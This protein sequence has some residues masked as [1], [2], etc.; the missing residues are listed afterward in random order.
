MDYTKTD[1]LCTKHRLWKKGSLVMSLV[2]QALANGY[3]FKEVVIGEPN[4]FIFAD[5]YE[6]LA[7]LF[8]KRGYYGI[9]I[10][11]IYQSAILEI[12]SNMDGVNNVQYT[13]FASDEATQ[14]KVLDDLQWMRTLIGPSSDGLAQ[15]SEYLQQHRKLTSTVILVLVA[16]ALYFLGVHVFLFNLIGIL[17]SFS[18]FLAIYILYIILRRRR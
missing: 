17:F 13:I 16:I 9:R 15:V 10:K 5:A 7:P 14:N 11:L 12:N 2:D 3:E 18:P 6:E 4:N 1:I 8:A